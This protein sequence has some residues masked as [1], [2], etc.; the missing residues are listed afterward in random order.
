MFDKINMSELKCCM[1]GM[2]MTF[3]LATSPSLNLITLSRQFLVLRTV[4]NTGLKSGWD[5]HDLQSGSFRWAWWCQSVI[6]IS[7]FGFDF[8]GNVILSFF[9]YSLFYVDIQ[10]SSGNSQ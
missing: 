3:K 5:M 6:S 9:F 4:K 1:N 2:D 7:P 8:S 10:Y